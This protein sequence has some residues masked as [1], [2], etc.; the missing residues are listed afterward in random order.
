MGVPTLAQP[1]PVPWGIVIVNALFEPNMD[2][3]MLLAMASSSALFPQQTPFGQMVLAGFELDVGT[4]YVNPA[5]QLLA[6]VV[7]PQSTKLTPTVNGAFA[8][9]TSASTVLAS[10][11]I[12]SSLL[13]HFVVV[14]GQTSHEFLRGREMTRG[15]RVRGGGLDSGMDSRVSRIGASVHGRR[16]AV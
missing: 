15:D 8:G 10:T 11:S 5:V 13:S 12:F 4:P 3:S 6:A 9:H 7:A 1:V 14:A 16:S 2:P